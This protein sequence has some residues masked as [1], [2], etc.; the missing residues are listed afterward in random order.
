[1]G[2][3]R[4]AERKENGQGRHVTLGDERRLRCGPQPRF[5]VLRAGRGETNRM[6]IALL[7]ALEGCCS[8]G[9]GASQ[10]WVK[11]AGHTGPRQREET[12]EQ[13]RVEDTASV[14]N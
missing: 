12:A 9:C 14:A 5:M 13:Q 10:E 8:V 6:A 2:R 4:R 7:A 3:P 11:L 1:M